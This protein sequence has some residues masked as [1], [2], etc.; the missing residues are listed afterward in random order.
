MARNGRMVPPCITACH[1]HRLSVTTHLP[2]SSPS[3]LLVISQKAAGKACC[4]TSERQWLTH[5]VAIGYADA[6]RLIRP[7][8]PGLYTWWPLVTAG[9][10]KN[11]GWRLDYFLVSP[12][13]RGNVRSCDVI[14]KQMG[15]DHCPIS[16]VLDRRP[17]LGPRPKTP[18]PLSSRA[19]PVRGSCGHFVGLGHHGWTW[20]WALGLGLG[21][22]T[23]TGH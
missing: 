21:A 13:L 18:H 14:D 11:E 23:G 9:R 8:V 4:T 20:D 19:M 16:L 1:L 6:L 10:A 22:R 2:T 15:S 3:P 7:G 17:K 5:M 12:D